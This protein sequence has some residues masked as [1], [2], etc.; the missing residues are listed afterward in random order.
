MGVVNIK[1]E[2]AFIWVGS[3]RAAAAHR[4]TR[5]Y[6]EEHRQRKRGKAGDGE[7]HTP[8]PTVAFQCSGF[9]IGT[10]NFASGTPAHDQL[11]GY[12]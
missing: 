4:S 11:L 6:T 5:R 1:D 2:F 9:N 3:G 8:D 12:P 7:Y 10:G